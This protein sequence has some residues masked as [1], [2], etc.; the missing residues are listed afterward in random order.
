MNYRNQLSKPLSKNFLDHIVVNVFEN[1]KDFEVVFKLIFDADKN[2]AW[3]AAWA[4]I[5]ISEKYPDWFNEKQVA[6]IID[7]ALLVSHPSLHRGCLSILYNL[8]LPKDIS[9]YFI[10]ACFEWM[11]SPK[12]PIAVQSLSMKILFEI[13][14]SDTDLSSELKSYLQ[15]IDS[16]CYSVGYNT[17]RKNILKKL[18]IS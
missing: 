17:V 7:F 12:Y 8:P 14:K 13:C 18:K 4:C 10:N 5:K 6:E 15:N 11:V 3:R 2:T 9:V 1:P 16:N